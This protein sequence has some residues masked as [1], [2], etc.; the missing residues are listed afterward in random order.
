MP[1][2]LTA[3]RRLT[4]V[5]ADSGDIE[6]I[7]RYQ[8][9][10]ATTNPA[11]ILKVTQMEEYSYLIS[12]AIAQVHTQS[13][14]GGDP[15]Q[16]AAEVIEQLLV[17]IALDILKII[18]GRLSLEID[19][20]LSYDQQASIERASRLVER[21]RKAGG[22]KQRILIKLAAT[23][24]GIQAAAVLEKQGIPCNL[25]LLFSFAQARACA[26]AGVY[27]ISP[28]VGR[29][30][31]WYQSHADQAN[32][33]MVD[34]KTESPSGKDPGVDFV[35]RVYNY[36][37]KHGYST[38]VMGASFRNIEQI[39]ALAGCDKLTI[40]P[41]LLQALSESDGFLSPR[42]CPPMETTPPPTPLT[43]AQFHWLHHQDA[44]AVSKL[45][46]GICQFAVAQQQLE[47][48]IIARL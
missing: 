11:L 10:D 44:M 36:Y 13:L 22:D 37:K 1:D 26:E 31:D 6:A 9:V 40:A 47:Q 14:Q 25:T 15:A 33:R 38:V 43:E 34:N 17:N 45:A 48:L 5:V 29:I 4:T 21:Y 2:T 3:L 12:E 18:P 39:V 7:R 8:P 20:R 32:A 16:W 46:E 41:A 27:L 24:Q 35:T 42:L 30:S 28:F 23:W 19:S